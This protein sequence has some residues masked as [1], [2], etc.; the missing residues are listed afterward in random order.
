M[1][2][3]RKKTPII[4]NTSAKSEKADK[5][6]CHKRMRVRGKMAKF[7]DV[8]VTPN[9]AMNVYTFAKD[10]KQFVGRV[11]KWMRK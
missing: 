7:D 2:R 1:S 6:M 5:K 3:S 4:G 11:S 9:D 10:G 8:H